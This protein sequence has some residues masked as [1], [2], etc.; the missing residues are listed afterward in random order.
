MN[1]SH[2]TS[3]R[4]AV[5]G[6]VRAWCGEREVALGSPQQRA[7]FA[8][9]LLRRGRPATV[10]ELVDAIW[11]EEPP[12]G[13][14]TVLR[15]YVSRLRKVLEPGRKPGQAPQVIVSA[16]D[17]YLVR[18]AQDAFDLGVFERRVAEARKLRTGG[19]LGAADEL[20][21]AA[22]DLWDGRPLAGVPGPLAVAER[23][24]LDEQ[25]LSTCETHL[26][27]G[28]ELGRHEEV[29]AR[30]SALTA[31]NPL[32]ERLYELL[33]LALYRSGRQAEALAAYGEIRGTLISELGVEPGAA[34]V[35]LHTRML[36]ADPSLRAPAPARS[37]DGTAASDPQPPKA[38][39]CPAQL[40]A[41]L[42]V[43]T[44]RE[45]EL[46]QT[47]SLLPADGG[48]PNAVVIS[49]IGGMAGV[50]KTTLAVHWAH[51]IAHRFPDGQLYVN[52]RGFDATGSAM[53]P[54]EA[55]HGFL[56][57]LG[58]PPGQIPERPDGR[59]ALFRGLLADRRV[60]LLLD[61]ARD[62]EQVRP[63]LPTG[64]GCLAVITSRNQ[65]T[66]LI[67]NDGAHPLTLDPLPLADARDFLA[68]RIGTARMAAEPEAADEIIACCGRLPLAL[69]IVAARAA[70]HPSF[71]LYAV[72]EE[73]RDN[74]GSL[75]A[76]A[77]GDIST[78]VRAVFSW[79]YHALSA[80]AARLFQLLAA[81]PGPDI[82]APATAALAGLD[83]R[84]TRGLLTELT[85]A[86]LL[87]EHFPGRYAFHDLLRIYAHEQA[88]CEEAAPESQQA[89]ERILSWYLHASAAASRFITPNRPRVPL[90]PLPEGCVAPRFTTYDQA[91]KWCSAERPNL[92]AAIKQAATGGHSAVAWRL[93]AVL[94][95]FFYLRSH[96][97]D[98]LSCNRVSLSAA[99]RDGDRKGAAEAL[100]GVANALTNAGRLDEAIDHYHQ[101]LAAWQLLGDESGASRITGNLGDVCLRAGRIEEALT[102]LHKALETYQTLGH[103][104]GEGIC[105]NNL[106]EAHLRLG[107]LDEAGTYLEQ[108]LEVQRATD[109]TWVEGISLDFLGTVH[110]R[111]Q[112]H[113]AAI[114][115]YQHA[116]A[117]HQAVGNRWGEAQTIDHLGDVH[118]ATGAPEAAREH[119]SRALALLEEFNHRDAA[120]IR[121]KLGALESE[122]D[123][124]PQS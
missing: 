22:L 75:D 71:P 92:I 109:N 14:V 110:H 21:R 3:L 117:K 5:L 123:S 53:H 20:L 113:E 97:N 6:P 33:M 64:P 12:S 17:G 120:G 29:A 104:W 49:A 102:H 19:S 41:D 85:H 74:H 31:G 52:L 79:S 18:V 61:N 103:G 27:L 83:L 8:T 112:R 99:R 57:A 107:R 65:L 68:R 15:T 35:D 77:G 80:P 76:F 72:A 67:A 10:G 119:W 84:E 101:A 73:L 34:L 36:S 88:D 42:P 60:L 51:E 4:V 111:L 94:W 90:L 58:V 115:H 95:G 70:T 26:D 23:Y 105:L 69:A 25:W 78:D 11:G 48:H 44:G 114:E 16:A 59:T 118:L 106:G 122:P 46:A 54:D 9:L 40:P 100:T 55:T 28:L 62:T 82:S 124:A 2:T 121:E 87:T 56:D 66:G 89:V 39:A 24:R 43:F 98:W 63:L 108:A 7:V 32:R 1:V 96:T 91:L 47:H 45:S 30:L 38:T 93:T 50:G 116:L 13:A 37:S 81:A 86:H